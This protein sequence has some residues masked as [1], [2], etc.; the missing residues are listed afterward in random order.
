MLARF[1]DISS[2][3]STN[4]NWSAYRAWAA[5]GDGEARVV[6]RSS[7]GTGVPDA[8]YTAF[9]SAAR[10]AGVSTV[11]HYHYAYPQFNSAID[12]ANYQASVIGQ[13]PLNDIIV[14]D[15]EESVSQATAQWALDWLEQ[16]QSNYPSNLIVFYTYRNYI[17]NRLQDERLT[18]WPLY[19][20]D[21][22]GNS[23]PVAPWKAVWALQY[24]DKATV[25]GFSEPIDADI[26]YGAN[27]IPK[28]INT[29]PV[30]EFAPGFT[31][32][33]CGPFSVAVIQGAHP[34][35]DS[36][37]GMADA[38]WAYSEYAKVNGDNGPGNTAGSSIPDM[39]TFLADAGLH[40]QEF[41]PTYQRIVAVLQHGYPVIATITEAGVYDKDLAGNPYWWGAQG[42]NILAIV[43]VD[44]D[45]DFLFFDTANVLNNGNLQ[46]TTTPLPWPRRYRASSLVYTGYAAVVQ[47]TWMPAIPGDIFTMGIPTGWHDDGTTLSNPTNGNVVRMGFR[48]HVLGMVPQWAAWDVPL[49]NEHSANP[50]EESNP[51]SGSGTRQVFEAEELAWTPS[52]GVYEI[53]AGRELKFV[54]DDRDAK[55][56]ALA[57]A[58]AEI[59]QLQAA[60]AAAGLPPDLQSAINT[61]VPQL[62][63]A[64]AELNSAVSD[65]NNLSGEAT[66]GAAQLTKIHD[67]LAPYVK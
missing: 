55:A 32:Y 37:A 8:N 2:F 63:A 10:A 34:G 28:V 4:I 11:L 47:P 38:N 16:Q 9:L 5:T 64:I 41:S 20:A 62:A 23:S 22:S 14:L 35:S 26:F 66:A 6:L 65:L 24:T 67:G 3:Q 39:R 54:R 61:I 15:Y 49:E 21:Y 43:G 59:A 18:R 53:W 45:G 58:Q 19:L 46:A 1:V 12:E 57:A 56:A 36:T 51:A 44:P 13:I 25:P 31:E 33:A 40:Y 27:V 17:P 50:V 7:Q 30:S 60:L 29:L 42:N 52:K 48:Q